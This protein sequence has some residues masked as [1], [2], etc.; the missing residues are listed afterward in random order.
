MVTLL[1]TAG[2]QV[3]LQDEVSLWFRFVLT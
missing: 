2:A 1:V 3:D